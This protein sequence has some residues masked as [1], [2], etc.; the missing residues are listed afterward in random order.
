[1]ASPIVAMNVELNVLLQ[2]YVCGILI[3]GTKANGLFVTL[4]FEIFMTNDN[5][6]FVIL[7]IEMASYLIGAPRMA[8]THSS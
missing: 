2:R 7:F 6:A 1:M 8:S 5:I 3:E 4:I